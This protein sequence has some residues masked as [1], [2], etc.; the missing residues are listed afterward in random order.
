MLTT[1]IHEVNATMTRGGHVRHN[2]SN[3]LVH[4]YDA[5]L[6]EQRLNWTTHLRLQR[7]LG[8]GGQGVV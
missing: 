5:I 2:A 1:T 8:T 4:R 6:R 3:E 7:L